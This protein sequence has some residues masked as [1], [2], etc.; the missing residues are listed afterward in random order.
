LFGKEK[1]VALGSMGYI[2]KADFACS[3]DLRVQEQTTD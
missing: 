3:A 1:Q 2:A